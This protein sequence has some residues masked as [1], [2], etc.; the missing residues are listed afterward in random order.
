MGRVRV[1]AASFAREDHL[2]TRGRVR[3]SVMGRVRVRA[4]SFTGLHHSLCKTNFSREEVNP[5][6]IPILILTLT[7]I[8]TS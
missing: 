8:L 6:P 5:I 3:V 7:V 4:A 1:R 2:F